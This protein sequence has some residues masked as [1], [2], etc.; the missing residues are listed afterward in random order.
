MAESDAEKTEAPSERK[1]Q[2][3]RD[4]GKVAQSKELL[5]GIGLAAGGTALLLTT[6]MFGDAFH[7]VFD[8]LR[9]NLS[10]AELTSSDVHLITA[11]IFLNVGPPLLIVLTAGS[12][13]SALAGLLLNNFNMAVGALEPKWERLD[14][15]TNFQSQ[16][17]SSQPWIQL[18]KSLLVGSAIGW[19]AWSAVSEHLDALPILASLGARAQ[20][21]YLVGLVTGFLQRVIPVGLAIG[22]ADY[23]WQWWRLQQEMMMTKEEARREHKEQEGDPKIKGKRKQIARQIAM[24]QMLTRVKEADVVVVNPTHY[25]V[26]LRYR[27]EEGRAPV[28]VA[29][30]L[31]LIA[32]KMR[33]EATRHEIPII[34]NR[35]LARGLY[36]RAKLGLPIPAEFYGAVAQLLAIVYRRRAHARGAMRPR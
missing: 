27:K 8:A 26:A 20:A 9:Q 34:E 1:I 2:Q 30:G 19:A 23:G 28:V 35:L 6:K 4:E 21:A 33:A 10:D 25:A 7:A 24:G 32:L 31:D 22:A 5:A 11:A 3:F 29:R 14:P 18:A 16:F 17:M 12:F 36:A 13:T 15:L